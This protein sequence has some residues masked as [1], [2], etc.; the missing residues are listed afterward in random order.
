MEQESLSVQTPAVSDE[1]VKS[2]A[3]EVFD[4]PSPFSNSAKVQSIHSAT[5]PSDARFHSHYL[6][7]PEASMTPSSTAQSPRYNSTKSEII[8]QA[9]KPDSLSVKED[10]KS[11]ELCQE[12]FNG[13]EQLV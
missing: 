7:T 1:D 4:L 6:P 10:Q 13:P 5:C 11:C 8:F 12:Q 3:R 2:D 9:L